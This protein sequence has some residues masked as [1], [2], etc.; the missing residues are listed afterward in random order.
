HARVRLLRYRIEARIRHMGVRILADDRLVRE[1]RRSDSWLA[2]RV[3]P[4]TIVKLRFRYAPEQALRPRQFGVDEF[5]DIVSARNAL[6]AR[7]RRLHR[8]RVDDRDD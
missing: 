2:F 4:D 3:L 8:L 7:H 6:L 5:N 1:D